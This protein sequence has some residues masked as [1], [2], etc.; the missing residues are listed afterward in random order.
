MHNITD[1]PDLDQLISTVSDRHVTCSVEWRHEHET[2]L[3]TAHVRAHQVTE[4]DIAEALDAGMRPSAAVGQWVILS[5]LEGDRVGANHEV[6][7]EAPVQDEDL[8]VDWHGSMSD[9]RDE[10]PT[11]D[12]L[13]AELKEWIEEHRLLESE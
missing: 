2:W 13:A 3:M 6:L 9:A 12:K 4:A 5:D 11:S 10:Q 1:R 8:W 7:G